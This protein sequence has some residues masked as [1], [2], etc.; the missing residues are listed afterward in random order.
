MVVWPFLLT[1]EG[2]EI[3][4]VANFTE[5]WNLTGSLKPGAVFISISCFVFYR[6]H[7]GSHYNN[8]FYSIVPQAD[9]RLP[10]PNS[11]LEH[12]NRTTT[13][14]LFKIKNAQERHD[15]TILQTFWQNK[16]KSMS[17]TTTH[18]LLGSLIFSNL[19]WQIKCFYLKVY[20]DTGQLQKF[21]VQ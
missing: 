6:A 8:T 17:Y 4:A 10:F 12:R 9:P 16:F 18:P 11:P 3:E 5:G 13:Q 19:L 14:F 1:S 20:T 2:M 15:N 21:H 7:L